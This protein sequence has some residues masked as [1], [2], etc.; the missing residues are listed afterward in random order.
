MT[1]PKNTRWLPAI[2]ALVLLFAAGAWAAMHHLSAVQDA[3]VW[4]R[5]RTGQWMLQ[6]HSLP[7]EVLFSQRA[8]GYWTVSGWGF[9][10]L[11]AAASSVFGLRAIPLLGMMLSCCA[12]A[13][14]FVLAGGRNPHRWL[15]AGLTALL[16][17]WLLGPLPC[18][19]SGVSVLLFGT[20]LA[21]LIDLKANPASRAVYAMP[22]VFLAWGMLA[23]EFLWGALLIVLFV[24]DTALRAWLEPGAAFST[25]AQQKRVLGLLLISPLTP[26]LTP[27]SYHLYGNFMA[28]LYGEAAFKYLPEM[29]ALGF[30]HPRDF[31]FA[32]FLMGAFFVLGRCRNRFLAFALLAALPIAYRIQRDA[33]PALLPAVAVYSSLWSAPEA[34]GERTGRWIAM[35]TVAALLLVLIGGPLLLSPARI[36]QALEEKLPVQAAAYVAAHRLPG[37]IY[38]TSAWG[39]YLIYALPEY[40]VALDSRFAVYG[41]AAYDA[42]QQLLLGQVSLDSDPSF[43]QAHTIILPA[44]T[45]LAQAM[46]K[47]PALRGRFQAVYED[48]LATVFVTQPQQLLQ[49]QPQL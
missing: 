16:A 8:G 41:D 14:L 36:E 49:P 48:P 45:A 10:V 25:Q 12:A 3:D 22:A 6:H 19:P 46:K 27:Y 28:E 29:N 23:P 17:L 44:N 30:R 18:N 13:V 47:L 15:P 35:G 34:E 4:W 21:L 37:P 33:W 42:Q 39:G 5:L 9:D 7:G 1:L 32:M 20:E 43:A 31:A 26:L 40:P 2:S 24:A 38:Q 11:L